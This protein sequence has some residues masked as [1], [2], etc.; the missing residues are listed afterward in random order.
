M[1]PSLAIIRRK[2]GMLYM[3]TMKKLMKRGH[4]NLRNGIVTSIKIWSILIFLLAVL[5]HNMN[6][7]R[8]LE[9]AA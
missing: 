3:I 9:S 7:V 8:K 6:R 1:N 5:G 4:L 2:Y